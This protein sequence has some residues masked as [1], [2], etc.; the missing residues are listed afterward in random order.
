MGR[1][2]GVGVGAGVEPGSCEAVWS[3]C[4]AVGWVEGESGWRE[5][6]LPV[7]WPQTF[8]FPRVQ[9]GGLSL[10]AREWFSAFNVGWSGCAD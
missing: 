4:W 1:E 9:G 5:E 3:S 8:H 7:S 10:L 6:L 2:G